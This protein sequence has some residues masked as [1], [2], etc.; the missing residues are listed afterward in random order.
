MP[1]TMNMHLP[2]PSQ[3]TIA[4]CLDGVMRTRRSA[5]AY[6]PDPVPHETLKDILRV[7]STAPS[8][9]NTQPWRVHVLGGDRKETLGRALVAAFQANKLPPS[10]HFPEPLPAVFAERQVEFARHYYA[11]LGI[12]RDDAGAR[13]LQTQRNF[14]FFGAP[15]GLIFTI[16]YRLTRH[17]W[18][19]LGLFVQSVMIA[20]QARGLDTCAQVSFARFHPVIAPLLAMEPEE[21]TVC[22]MALGYGDHDL[23]VNR[24]TI[25]RQPLDEFVRFH[26]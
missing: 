4:E 3:P 11:S 21:L 23:A 9:S 15:V 8:N 25:P 5:R 6:K 1:E 24:M 13:V 10:P 18:L 19:D 2:E 17:S 7:A 12:E 26:D 22:G 20:A 16:D 14:S